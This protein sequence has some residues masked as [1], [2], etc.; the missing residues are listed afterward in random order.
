MDPNN[1]GNDISGGSRLV[2]LIFKQFAQAHDEILAAMKE[3]HRPSLLDWMIGGDYTDVMS[4]RDHMQV[5]YNIDGS[6]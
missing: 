5:L 6:G 3:R 2:L 4:Q 1:A